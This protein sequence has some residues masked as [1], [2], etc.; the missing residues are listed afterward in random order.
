MLPSACGAWRLRLCLFEK[1]YR[2]A[3]YLKKRQTIDGMRLRLKK[4]GICLFCSKIK[5][6]RVIGQTILGYLSSPNEAINTLRLSGSY[7][8]DSFFIFL[9]QNKPSAKSGRAFVLPNGAPTVC[10]ALYIFR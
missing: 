6:A 2:A 8:L 10:L 7:S 1:R 4:G 9:Y 5:F 3:E